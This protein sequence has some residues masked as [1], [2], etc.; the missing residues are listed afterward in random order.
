[1]NCD[2]IAPWYRWFEY[3]GFGR[4]LERRREAFLRDVTSARRVL[5][6]GDGD[7][8]ALAALLRANSQ[9]TVDYIDLSA[10]ML[11]LAQM[12]VGEQRVVY[13]HADALTIPLPDAEYDLVVTHFFLDCLDASGQ[14]RLV[15]RM[16]RALSPGGRWL[17][18]EFCKAG[19]FV[20]LLYAFFRLTTGLHTRELADYRT[21][22]RRHGFRLERS[23]SAWGGRLV[24]E[25]WIESSGALAGG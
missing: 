25:L 11:E 20:A 5:V 3:L 17:V 7:G 1:M 14:E 4:A 23:E 2:A 24:S 15:E 10:R 21:L 18:S 13:H 8:R 6:L 12:R 19:M 9:A 22:F 16:R